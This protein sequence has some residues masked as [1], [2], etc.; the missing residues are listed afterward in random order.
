[1]TRHEVAE[2]RLVFHGRD[3]DTQRLKVV[4]E[5]LSDFT[6]DFV[7]VYHSWGDD[8]VT[9]MIFTNH[10]A[11]WLHAVLTRILNTWKKP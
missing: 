2:E 3:V 9:D 4:T 5:H 11:R 8:S 7:H 10:E 6:G 1:M